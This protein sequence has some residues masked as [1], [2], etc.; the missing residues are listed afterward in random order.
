MVAVGVLVLLRIAQYLSIATLVYD[1]ELTEMARLAI[2]LSNGDFIFD[3][4]LFFAQKYTFQPFSQGTLLLQLVTAAFAVVLGPTGWALQSAVLLFETIA[5]A[6]LLVVGARVGGRRGLGLAALLWLVATPASLIAIQLMPYGIHS[7]FLF[8]PLAGIAFAA[9]RPPNTWGIQLWVAASL[10]MALGVVL[11]RSNLFPTLAFTA[12]V[13]LVHRGRSAALALASLIGAGLFGGL[14]LQWLSVGGWGAM[15]QHVSPGNW[16][17]LEAIGRL[18]DLLGSVFPAPRVWAPLDLA[19]R[20]LLLLGMPLA[21][22][23]GLRRRTDHSLILI[24]ASLW[25]A[26]SLAAVLLLGQLQLRYLCPPF[27]ALL[28]CWLML[29]LEHGVSARARKATRVVLVLLALG[30]ASDGVQLIH[31]SVWSQTLSFETVRIGQELKVRYVELD[32]LPYL[33]R[34]LDE[35]RGSPWI[36]G[37]GDLLGRCSNLPLSDS[38]VKKIRHPAK[39]DCVMAESEDPVI[40]LREARNWTDEDAPLE[41]RLTDMGRGAWIRSGRDLLAME[42]RL[43]GVTQTERD[44]LLAGARDE[45]RRWGQLAAPA[46]D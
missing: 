26:M 38:R 3:S 39:L 5:F 33:Q 35:G 21:L 12:A 11:F 45:A 31:P 19:W 30:G 7:E 43:A 4:P 15:P 14:I 1:D 25:T 46:G 10:W 8:I 41:L 22:F 42:Q 6:G 2:D 36:G 17:P 13:I 24:F 32:E 18:P 40:V 9:H 20:L 44:L 29:A 27:Y 16:T 23:R 28:L 34:I 37:R